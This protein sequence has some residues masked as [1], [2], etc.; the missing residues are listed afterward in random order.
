MMQL[1]LN[2]IYN[3]PLTAK[4]QLKRLLC[5]SCRDGP[6]LNNRHRDSASNFCQ[7]RH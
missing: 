3:V 2:A 6:N 1:T 5:R 4:L 7:H